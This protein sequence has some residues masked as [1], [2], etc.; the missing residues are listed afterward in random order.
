MLKRNSQQVASRQQAKTENIRET[1]FPPHLKKEPQREPFIKNLLLPKFD[2]AILNYPVTQT[3]D[4][5]REFLKWLKP[6]EN[7]ISSCAETNEKLDKQEVLA[8]LR[9]LEVFRA[10]MSEEHFGLNLSETETLKV[11]ETLSTL[12]WLGSYIVKNYIVPIQIISKYGSESQQKEY[13]PKIMS[14]ET[15]PTVCIKED[16]NGTNINNIKCNVLRW[17]SDSFLLNG[18]KSYVVNGTDSNLFIVF[19]RDLSSN[20][21]DKKCYSAL[22]V[23]KDYEGVTFS[24]VH[25]MI[26]RHEIPVCSVK[27][28]NTV[29]PRRNVIGK[30]GGAFN[31]MMEQLKPGRQ[32]VTAQAISILRNFINRLIA[33]VI[34]IKHMDRNLH[35]FESVKRILGDMVCTLYT[36]ES[37]AYL[38][39]GLMDLYE[40]QDAEIERIITESYCA[41]KCLNCIQVGLQLLGTQSYLSDNSYIKMFYDALALTTFD[42][43]NIN[44]DIYVASAALQHVGQSTYDHIFKKRNPHQ[45]PVYRIVQNF[46]T[47]KHPDI[48]VAC[49]LHPSLQSSGVILEESI[50]MLNKSIMKLLEQYG[51][52]ITQRHVELSRVSTMMTDL[53][54][55]TANL[56]RASRSYCIGLRHADNER[57]MAETMTYNTRYKIYTV[58]QE[59]EEGDVFNGDYVYKNTVDMMYEQHQYP[60]EH[61]TTRNF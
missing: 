16:D 56:S 29:I 45:Y 51:L 36:M 57:N 50:P 18:E 1:Y 30:P 23:E 58:N 24:K 59:I 3:S 41:N 61:P 12:P 38:T 40:N 22:L 42:S 13:F 53:Y 32:N 35:E 44:T 47:W 55:I 54:G 5:Y 7:Y 11:T 8:N 10:C 19:A 49:H 28:E 48:R 26:G 17:E 6:I 43:S 2:P 27:F 9:D 25:K 20:I 15:I 4:R 31:I 46:F 39:S 52:E 34:E 37:M 33:G 21:I 14:G 60:I